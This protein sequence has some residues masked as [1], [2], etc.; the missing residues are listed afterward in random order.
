MEQ[1][2]IDSCAGDSSNTNDLVAVANCIYGKN[3]GARGIVSVLDGKGLAVN[4]AD[5]VNLVQQTS[6]AACKDYE[7]PC[8]PTSKIDTLVLLPSPSS[9]QKR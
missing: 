9:S 4:S 7:G 3:N 8:T 6:P 1:S 2:Q 5:A